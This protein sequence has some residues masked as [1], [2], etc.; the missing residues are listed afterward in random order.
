[1]TPEQFENVL[2][3]NPKWLP[4]ASSNLT[5]I[6]DLVT[7]LNFFREKKIEKFL[8]V[9]FYEG[10][11]LTSVYAARPYSASLVCALEKESDSD[12]VEFS[13][14]T[15]EREGYDVNIHEVHVKQFLQ[16]NASKFNLIYVA[17]FKETCSVFD[18]T[19][20]LNSLKTDGALV[21]NLKELSKENLEYLKKLKYKSWAIGRSYL[22]YENT[23]V[24]C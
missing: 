9:G 5:R 19:R 18:I 3:V 2:Q 8:E 20:L 21:I 14:I 17:S 16:S 12:K 7:L 24:I 10:S 22:I 23:P 1:M 11:L 6:E 4:N 13:R 15:L